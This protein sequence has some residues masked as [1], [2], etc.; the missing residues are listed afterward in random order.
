MAITVELP[1]ETERAFRAAAE[2]RG[3]DAA[4]MIRRLIA[5]FLPDGLPDA[6]G[7]EEGSLADL[8]EG[9]IGRIEGSGEPVARNAGALF[10]EH[11]QER[12][13]QGR[14]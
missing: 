13:R 7:S 5:E 4:G 3:E 2:A 10:S 14:L 12:R 9:R 8:L 6:S 1:R 11:L